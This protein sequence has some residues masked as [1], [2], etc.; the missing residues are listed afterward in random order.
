MPIP[1]N[2][3]RNDRFRT[4]MNGHAATTAAQTKPPLSLEASGR[5]RRI[6]VLVIGYLLLYG[7]VLYS[8]GPLGQGDVASLWYP[9]AGLTV[10]GILAFGWAGVA[11]AIAGNASILLPEAAWRGSSFSAGDFLSALVLH[12]AAYAVAILPLR[13]LV[14]FPGFLVQPAQVG[15]F[16]AAAALGAALAT[17]GEMAR[18]GWRGQIDPDHLRSV[19]STWLASNFFG[20]VALAPMLLTGVLPWL[21]R[22]LMGKSGPNPSEW[23]RL[24]EWNANI[25][26]T[27]GCGAVLGLPL[28]ALGNLPA[29]LE[30]SHRPFL[31]LLLLLPLAWASIDGGIRQASFAVFALSVGLSLW[32]RIEP[33]QQ[34]FVAQYQLVAIAIAAIGLL[35]GGAMEAR[36]RARVALQAHAAQLER[37]LI[38]KV[39]DLRSANQELATKENYL[40]ALVGAAPVGIAQFDEHGRCCYLNAV[41]C[42]LAACSE[43]AARGRYFLDFVHPDDR[44]YVEFVWQTNGADQQVS[45]LEFRLQDSGAW[46]SSRWIKVMQSVELPLAGSIVILADAA[47]QRRKDERIWTQAHYDALTALPNRN[48]FW[49][50]L[51]QVLRRAKRDN[52]Q[53][54]LLWIDLDG[55]KAINDRLG[56]AAGDE[57]LRQAAVRLNGR[58]RDS[59]TVARMGGD[60]FTVILPDIADLDAAV[61]V[62]ANL[63]VR[64]AEPFALQG[65]VGRVSASIGVS[66]YP[67]HA[68][69]AEA[70]VKCADVA[71]YAAKRAGKNRVQVWQ[72]TT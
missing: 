58:I 3:N 66:L 28:L 48:L 57:L 61:G 5:K 20:I 32:P 63:V 50:R 40:R 51:D 69:S 11:L 53:V 52:Q 12:A 19:A 45:S 38:A 31:L 65:D 64:L 41:G 37:E 10:F 68:E 67:P 55:F 71:M 36:D 72:P 30:L 33:A 13:R 6:A 14:G 47:E 39:Q 46:V 22:W 70:L 18:L 4:K 2:D 25:R 56:H 60:E 42:T 17:G 7:G 35:L 23:L 44:D 16:L 49:E 62:A 59:D 8:T 21:Q 29:D 1:N 26:R 34:T 27:L 9:L 24:E 15:W 54:A 43:E